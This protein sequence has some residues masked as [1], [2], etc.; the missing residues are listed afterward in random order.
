MRFFVVIT[1]SYSW[2]KHTW[3]CSW[4]ETFPIWIKQRLH[5]VFLTIIQ[6]F[7]Y[8]IYLKIISQRS[9]L[10]KHGEFTMINPPESLSIVVIHMG[11]NDTKLSVWTT[12]TWTEH[13][14]VQATKIQSVE[15]GKIS[16]FHAYSNYGI[17]HLGFCLPWCQCKQNIKSL[18]Q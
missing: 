10:I 11:L 9:Y 14:F 16:H 4:G 18:V 3:T 7:K 1:W 6:E 2:P 15:P 8:L 13:V 17:M 5:S 12:Q